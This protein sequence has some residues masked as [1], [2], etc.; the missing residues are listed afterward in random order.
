MKADLIPHPLLD[1]TGRDYKDGRF[2]MVVE[3]PQ[4]TIDGKILIPAKL[5]IESRFM[6]DLM[7]KK[8]ARAFVVAR[9]SKTYRRAVFPTD[10]LAVDLKLPLSEYRDRITVSAYLA[11]TDDIAPF[12]SGEHHDDFAGMRI[13]VPAGGI[14]ARSD[15]V[16]LTIDSLQTLSAAIRIEASN[17]LDDGQYDIDLNDDFILIYVNPDTKNKIDLLRRSD[18]HKLFPSL[19]MVAIMHAISNIEEDGSKKWEEALK[20]TLTSMLAARKRKIDW[21]DIRENSYKH[22]QTLLENPMKH[23]LGGI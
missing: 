21:N 12:E 6:R 13:R 20:K 23:L 17:R 10:G 18:M 14:L 8:R 11:A 15:D 2:D 19:Y 1:P 16:E 5:V 4:H 3:N 22:A 7:H 9:C